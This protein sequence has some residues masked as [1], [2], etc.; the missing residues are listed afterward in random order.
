MQEYSKRK[1]R[2]KASMSMV[3]KKA[4]GTRIDLGKVSNTPVLRYFQRLLVNYRIRK[5]RSQEAT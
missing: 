1:T 2:A 4:D 5:Y 3:I